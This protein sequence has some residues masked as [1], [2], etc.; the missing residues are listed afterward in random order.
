MNEQSQE[1]LEVLQDQ[2]LQ[3]AGKKLDD[4][5]DVLGKFPPV[6]DEELADLEEKIDPEE[7]EKFIEAIKEWEREVDEQLERLLDVLDGG[8]DGDAK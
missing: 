6:T 1:R 8:G 3:A 7:W 4:L 5:E 2:A